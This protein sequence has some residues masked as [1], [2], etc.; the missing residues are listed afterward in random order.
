[1]SIWTT[2]DRD[3]VKDAIISLSTGKRVV[4]TDIGGKQ[5]EFG[6][7]SLP[8]LRSLL[9]EILADIESVSEISGGRRVSVTV[10]SDTW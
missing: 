1:M 7:A 8:A 2:T 6:T 10:K 4:Q 5:R 9:A 3:N